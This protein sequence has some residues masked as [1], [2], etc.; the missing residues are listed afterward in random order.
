MY[1]HL[2]KQRIEWTPF[3]SYLRDLHNGVYNYTSLQPKITGAGFFRDLSSLFFRTCMLPQSLKR[4]VL[5]S[6]PIVSEMSLECAVRNAHWVDEISWVRESM[7]TVLLS[8]SIFPCWRSWS[9][10]DYF[11]GFRKR[12]V[13]RAKSG[14]GLQRWCS[15]LWWRAHPWFASWIVYMYM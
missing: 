1:L 15:I 11:E 8:A 12:L 2:P 4:S 6:C 10:Q 5:C 3:D 13:F 7:F 9:N 14:A